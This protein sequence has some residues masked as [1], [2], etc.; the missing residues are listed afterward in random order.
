MKSRQKTIQELINKIKKRINSLYITTKSRIYFDKVLIDQKDY[1]LTL[2]NYFQRRD[3]VAT[4]IHIEFML[5]NNLW[6]SSSTIEKPS[7]NEKTLTVG[8]ANLGNSKV[9]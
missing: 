5:P 9:L 2:E 1:K 4:N 6:P 3:N 8:L 7:N